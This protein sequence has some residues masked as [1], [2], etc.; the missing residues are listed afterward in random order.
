MRTDSEIF[1]KI[2]NVIKVSE[3]LPSL[4]KKNT[5]SFQQSAVYFQKQK[6]KTLRSVIASFSC[7]PNP[8]QASEKLGIREGKKTS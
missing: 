5:H 3:W 2:Q 7:D 8:P 1:R 4:K 6:I